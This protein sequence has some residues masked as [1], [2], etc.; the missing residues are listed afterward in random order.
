[1]PYQKRNVR[2]IHRDYALREKIQLLQVFLTGE[3]W[4]H[5]DF[6][7]SR[8]QSIPKTNRATLYLSSRLVHIAGTLRRTPSQEA[9]SSNFLDENPKFGIKLPLHNSTNNMPPSKSKVP[10]RKPSAM[11]KPLPAAEDDLSDNFE[12]LDSDDPMEKD[13]IELELEKLVFGDEAGFHEGLRSHREGVPLT[14][15]DTSTELEDA[16]EVS[17]EDPG[18]EGVDDAGVSTLAILVVR[19]N[20]MLTEALALLS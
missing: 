11:S 14:K 13:E 12:G 20:E 18:L 4:I 5:V 1:M 10:S 17:D 8:S 16:A 3:K 9:K 2:Y 7:I 15:F 6:N 19:S